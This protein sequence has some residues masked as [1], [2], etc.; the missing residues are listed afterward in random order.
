MISGTHFLKTWLNYQNP[1]SACLQLHLLIFSIWLS[2]LLLLGEGRLLEAFF[3]Q[4]LETE[5]SYQLM[6]IFQ[7]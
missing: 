4:Q 3:T 2:N 7:V 5:G 1:L 6:S